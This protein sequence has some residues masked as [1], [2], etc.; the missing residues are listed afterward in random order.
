M[1][2]IVKLRQ[3]AIIFKNLVYQQVSLVVAE[4][5]TKSTKEKSVFPSVALELRDFF[6][7]GSSYVVG[8]DFLLS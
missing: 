8:I 1:K 4:L 5:L 2:R 6:L 7:I 3:I